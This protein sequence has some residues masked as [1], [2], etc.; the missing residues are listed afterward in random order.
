MEEDRWAKGYIIGPRQEIGSEDDQR[1]FRI[2]EFYRSCLVGDR[3][4]KMYKTGISGVW[5]RLGGTQLYKVDQCCYQIKEDEMGGTTSMYGVTKIVY[6]LDS[7]GSRQILVAGS[8]ER[9][10]KSF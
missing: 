5:G 7:S 1:N 10:K 9:G 3:K 4:Q 6:V 2:K 8:S